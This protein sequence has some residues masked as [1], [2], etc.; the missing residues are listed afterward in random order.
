MK[1]IFLL[2]CSY[3]ET[4]KGK[5][6][7]VNNGEIQPGPGEGTVSFFEEAAVMKRQSRGWL[8]KRGRELQ[9]GAFRT[10]ERYMQRP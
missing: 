2:Q 7:R 10:K 6:R 5:I 9:V 4:Y 3:D 8:D 1:T